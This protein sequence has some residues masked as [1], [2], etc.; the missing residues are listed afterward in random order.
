MG[1]RD[2]HPRAQNESTGCDCCDDD[3]EEEEEGVVF[4]SSLSSIL[5]PEATINSIV[6]RV[7]SRKLFNSLGLYHVLA[8]AK[9]VVGGLYK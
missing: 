1:V 9:V 3:E 7:S 6:R 2:S 4:S 8:L 5:L